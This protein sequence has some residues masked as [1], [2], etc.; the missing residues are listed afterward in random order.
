MKV[1]VITSGEYSE[2]HI[3]AVTLDK[4]YAETL[5]KLF[6]DYR[7]DKANIEIWD[8]D[9]KIN[10]TPGMVPYRVVF[11][12]TKV[13]TCCRISIKEF[14]EEDRIWMYEDRGYVTLEAVDEKHAIKIASDMYAK[15]RAE[16]L[17]L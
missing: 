2:Y 8:T 5:S 6:G 3:C 15:Y 1:Y 17:G 7:S 14:Y 13:V 12:G 9:T 4:E 10:F 16:Q 11:E